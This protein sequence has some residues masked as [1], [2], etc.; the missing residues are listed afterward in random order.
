MSA[1]V[2]DSLIAKYDVAGPRYTSYPTVPYW[3]STPTQQLWVERV[4]AALEQRTPHGAALYVHIPFCRALCTFCGCNTR[5]TRSHSFVA[6]YTD[7]LLK[8]LDL[9]L[10]GLGR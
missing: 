6:P 7:A 10:S 3:E 8:E 4:R 9:Y 5:I 2:A 1:V